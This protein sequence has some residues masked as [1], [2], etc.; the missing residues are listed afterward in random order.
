MKLSEETIEAFH[1]SLSRCQASRDFI[2]RFYDKFVGSHPAVAAKFAGVNMRKQAAVLHASLHMVVL[3][4]QNN[5]AA[6]LYLSKIAE[7]H[8]RSRLDIAPELYDFW[9]ESLMETVAESDPH[10]SAAIERAWRDILASGIAFMRS[11]Y[12]AAGP[13]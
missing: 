4:S 5:E 3:A 6:E 2:A 8:A 10:Y 9:L 1:D 11:R 12:D 7:K 13:A